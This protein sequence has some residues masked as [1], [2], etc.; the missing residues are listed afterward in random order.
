M[1]EINTFP[2]TE[3]REAE[4]KDIEYSH[5]EDLVTTDSNGQVINAKWDILKEDANKA[6]EF[7]H[8]FSFWAAI[9]EYRA[10]SP[11]N[12]SISCT[13]GQTA[14]CLLVFC[15]LVIDHYGR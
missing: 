4:E 3:E 2:P 9:K 1:E 6:E 15:C 11:G 7:D 13:E 5:V 10:V 8:S 12:E 14:G